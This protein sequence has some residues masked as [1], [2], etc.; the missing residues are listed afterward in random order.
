MVEEGDFFKAFDFFP[1]GKPVTVVSFI[2]SSM[3]EEVGFLKGGLNSGEP[4][5]GAENPGGEEVMVI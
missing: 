5:F 1:R 4:G 2:K 3:V